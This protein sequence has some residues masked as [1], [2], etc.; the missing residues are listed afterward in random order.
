M[1][2]V[3]EELAASLR[4]WR[5]RVSPA[6][7]GLPAGRSRRVSGLRRE[8]VAQL[9][10]V[11]VDYLARLEQGRASSPSPSV[12]ASLA[13]ALRL[14][15]DERTH[16]FEL[17]GQAPPGRGTIDRHITPSLQRLLDRLADVPVLVLDAACE[18]I[19][20][21]ALGTA[22]L[23]DLSG[24][25][26][27]ERNIAWRVFTRAP[28]TVVRT[29]EEWATAEVMHVA[30]LRIAFARHPQ[31]EELCALI[32]ELRATRPRFAELWEQRP[33]M[34]APSRRK[35]FRH[36]EVGV[37]T[38]DCEALA[39]Q[40]SDLELIV[41]TATPGTPDADALALLATIGLQSFDGAS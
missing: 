35:R 5:G 41:Y 4:S 36:P 3:D 13:R 25:P 22:L 14:S 17:A 19:A 38:L 37:I 28:T 1:A 33:V 10:G 39:V 21:N 16:L 29:E 12:L 2:L 31:D 23:G 6:D 26:R 15:G 20:M 32:E 40:G 27:R 8:E 11:S 18:T 9:A 7:A 30:D 34:P 24:L